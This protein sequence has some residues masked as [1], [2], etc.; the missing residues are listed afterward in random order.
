VRRGA[1][2]TAAYH[3]QLT[4]AA[5]VQARPEQRVP[6][7]SVLLRGPGLSTARRRLPGGAASR[8]PAG[9][10]CR[11]GRHCQDAAAASVT[12]VRHAGVH[13]AGSSS[14]IRLSS[15]SGVQPVR[16]PA[17]CC[18]P[19]PVSSRLLST[20]LS[21][22]VRLPP[23]PAVA[24]GPGRGGRATVTTATGRGPGGRPQPRAAGS[25]AEEP[26]GGRRRQ[27]RALV[28]RGVGGGPGPGWGGRRPPLPA[29]R[30]GRPGRRAEPPVAGGGAVGQAGPGASWAH[31]PRSCR[32][33]AGW[34]DHGGW[35][36]WRRP[37][38][39]ATR[40]GCRPG[41]GCGPSAAQGGSWRSRLVA[42]SA[43][44]VMI[45]VAWLDLNLGPHPE[46]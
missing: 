23:P 38:G 42:G 22:R 25:T 44:P 17:V 3:L 13:P 15:P 30:P 20:P 21:G 16:C 26:W 14:G 39:V 43:G 46:T 11:R 32:P 19:R 45:M 2:W 18:P 28:S 10:R 4:A 33:R 40:S 27:A 12:A 6:S 24:L 9:R 8:H 35:W 34:G 1:S 5:A 7:S 31:R 37:V 41:C 36:S 29:A